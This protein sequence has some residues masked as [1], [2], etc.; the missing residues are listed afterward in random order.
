MSEANPLVRI[1]IFRIGRPAAL[2]RATGIP[3]PRIADLQ[4]GNQDQTGYKVLDLYS[5]KPPLYAVYRTEQRVA[6]QYADSD[7]LADAQRKAMMPLNTLRGEIGGLIDGWRLQPPGNRAR[8]RA[9]RY[10]RRVAP[11]LTNAFEGDVPSA[12]SQLKQIK[13]DIL[14]ERTAWARFMYLLVA[15]LAGSIVIGIIA[16]TTSRITYP[17]AGVDL[18]RAAATG[19]IG[20]FFSIALAIRG[21]TVLPD[22]Q[23]VANAMDAALRMLIGIIAAGVLMALVDAHAITLGFGAAQ[24]ATANEATRPPDPATA[25]SGGK[26]TAR[27]PPAGNSADLNGA[28]SRSAVNGHAAGWSA[29]PRDE[30]WLYVL[31]VG[32]IAGF[33]ERFVPDLLAKASASTQ[34]PAT[35]PAAAP[36]PPP[37]IQPVGAEAPPT[38]QVIQST[39][40]P[41]P[42]QIGLD[43]CATKQPITAETATADIDLPPASGGV[44]ANI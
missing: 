1:P 23:W 32:F 2:T 17:P 10:D 33:S 37:A 38:T 18:W 26:G 20:A 41:H 30:P 5:R 43:D 40:D 14:D 25:T 16:I 44:A 7:E 28:T 21:R 12:E 31:I 4:I 27:D 11:A 34:A 42:E 9:D 35:T 15:F 13:Q 3:N 8:R 36:P 6:I 29:L 24:I 39:T 22:L 19:A